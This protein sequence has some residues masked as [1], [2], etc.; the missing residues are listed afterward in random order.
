MRRRRKMRRK[1]K[2]KRRRRRRRSGRVKESLGV[3]REEK[4]DNMALME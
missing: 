2:R 3:K 4:N 1:R